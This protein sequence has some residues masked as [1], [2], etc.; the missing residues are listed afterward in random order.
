MDMRTY[1]DKE[2]ISL[3]A[4]SRAINVSAAS[5]YRYLAGDRIPH[6]AV[7]ERIVQATHGQV[8]PNDFFASKAT[9]PTQP[10]PTSNDIAAE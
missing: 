1:L 3:A 10:P 8:Q 5:M 6:R 2:K 7:M 9:V 4:F